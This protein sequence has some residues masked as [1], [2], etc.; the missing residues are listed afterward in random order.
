LD[1]PVK[2]F[3]NL[4]NSI[5]VDNT[6]FLKS[7]FP[8]LACLIA[9]AKINAV[10][11][12]KDEN[13]VHLLIVNGTEAEIGRY[14]YFAINDNGN[15]GGFLIAQNI[16]LTAAHCERFFRKGNKVIIGT[17]NFND[18]EG[19][20]PDFIEIKKT[21]IHPKYSIDISDDH[22]FMLVV[23]KSGSSFQPVII[24]ETDDFL[25]PGDKVY[26]IGMGKTSTFGVESDSLLEVD[27]NY[28]ENDECAKIYDSIGLSV[29]KTMLCT[30]T[31]F[32]DACGGDSGGPLIKRGGNAENDVVVGIT[33]WGILCADPEFPGVF[34][35]IST[36]YDWIKN[37]VERN[38]GELVSW[39]KLKTPLPSISLSETPT[40]SPSSSQS[41][42]EKSDYIFFHGIKENGEPKIRKCNWL[43]KK[44][45]LRRKQ[46]CARRVYYFEVSEVVFSPANTV[47]KDS[48]KSCGPC[49]E[50]EKSKYIFYKKGQI[51]IKPCKIV[52]RMSP[53]AREKVCAQEHFNSANNVCP[54]SCEVGLC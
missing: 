14:D 26:A 27:L 33:S 43:A 21:I 40:N 16:V 15:C 10:D 3:H 44:S 37:H 28:I 11:S 12:K 35:R 34:A 7:L 41:S 20:G 19:T 50:H 17:Y 54:V 30:F 38:G 13:Q 29:T 47:C 25:E 22:D 45:E 31:K 18:E 6:M 23:L 42:C 8:F 53:A 9:P 1:K 39:K 51:I 36:K 24:P 48:C 2:L 4:K 52:S 49:Y 32:K 5:S 46:I